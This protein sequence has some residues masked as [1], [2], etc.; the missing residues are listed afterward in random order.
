MNALP[1]GPEHVSSPQNRDRY[2]EDLERWGFDIPYTAF[3]AHP[4]EDIVGRLRESYVEF[5]LEAKARGYPACIQIQSTVCAGDRVGIEEA[6]YDIRNQPERW[7]ERG[8]FASFSSNVWLEYLKQITS[9]FVK[10]YGYNWVVF[11]E[12][13]YRVDIPG[14]Q[15]RFYQKFVQ[16]RPDISYPV[17]RD[18][19]PEYLAVQRAKAESLTKFLAELVAHAKLVGAERVGVMPWFFIPTI[20]NT[21]PE[22]LN[23]SCNLSSISRI[24]GLDFLVVRMQPDNIYC[25]TM[26]TGDEM[27][28]SPLLY[29]FEVMAHMVGKPVIAVSNPSDEHTDYPCLPLIPIEFYRDAT[30][31]ELCAAPNGFTRH[32]YAQNY[33]ADSEHM[34]I[35]TD[36]AACASRLGNVSSPV[37]FVFSYDGTRHARP[38][39]YETVFAYYWTI[40]KHLTLRYHMPVLTF[41]AETLSDDLARHPEVRVLIFDEHFPLTREQVAVLRGW[42]TRDNRRAVVV[43][44]S[45]L[46]YSAEEGTAGA[47][48]SVRSL[49]GLME[50]A[51]LRQ[52]EDAPQIV[53]DRPVALRFSAGMH[54]IAFLGDEVVVDA[55][56]LANVRRVFGSVTDVIYVAEVDGFHVPVV[57]V[58]RDRSMLA[59]VCCFGISE[60]TADVA[61]RAVMFALKDTHSLPL[62]VSDASDG[63][64]WNTNNVGYLIVGNVSDK[65]GRVRLSVGR[66]LIWDVYGWRVLADG[67]CEVEV[68]PHGFRLYRVFGRRSKL[69]D[70]IG[71]SAVSALV[72]GSGRA[73]VSLVCGRQTQLIVRAVP[74][75]VLVDG[76]QFPIKCEPAGEVFCVT[77]EGCPPGE[78][79]ISVRW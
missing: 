21:P 23:P 58:Y 66:R 17:S 76:R 7:G 26:R 47:V 75:L 69:L 55:R 67:V 43:F 13:M 59:I 65:L 1:V 38:W 33:G 19:S 4:Y 25:G 35:L 15:D 31:A 5:A 63:I 37:A 60:S 42:W 28:N 40:I 45:G 64:L 14:S 53:L 46:G 2:F 32:W 70:V 18:E 22:T 36:V 71:A 16:A 27:T 68:P 6:Q 3:Y 41:H 39:T 51:G 56:N 12:P 49:P 48:P 61:C 24:E 30:I 34:K 74:E 8:F 20:E 50:L 11:E 78:H 72:D 77:V 52:V 57:S 54:R 29:Y 79:L 9:I 73:D 62:I 44:V 10:E